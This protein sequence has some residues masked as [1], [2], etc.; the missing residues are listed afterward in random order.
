MGKLLKRCLK[1]GAMR[2][3]V[4]VLSK[5]KTNMTRC[6]GQSMHNCKSIGEGKTNYLIRF[7]EGK[8]WQW[9]NKR[10]K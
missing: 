10:M 4:N 7:N 9:L 5:L 3:V 2:C 1:S 6:S 8:L